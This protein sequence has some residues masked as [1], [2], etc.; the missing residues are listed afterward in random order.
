MTISNIQKKKFLDNIY[1]LMYST[2]VSET[3]TVVRQPNELEVKKEFDN[4]FSE[5]RLGVPLS[6]DIN[7][8]RNS[9]YTN[10]DL[11]NN[12]MA[13]SLLNMEVLYDSVHE[14]NEDL[15]KV[16]TILSK[17]LDSLKN[18][19]TVLEKKVD[20]ALFA[21]AN[22]DGYFYSFGESFANLNNVDL[23]L[24]SC[25]VDTENR[26]ATLPSLKSNALDFRAPGK[27]N[28]SNI[29]YDII[30]N[31]ATVVSSQSLP[32]AENLFDGLNDTT[33]VV[34]YSGPNLGVCAMV[35]T[36]P[37]NTP[38][39]IS[40]IDGKLNTSSSIV[41][42]AE[43]VDNINTTNAQYRRKQSNSSYDR[44]SFDFNPQSSGLIKLTFIK[45]QPDTT[46]LDRTNDKYTFRFE[47][48]DLIVS[49]QYY[50]REATLV[51]SPI[52]IDLGNDNKII[53]AVSIDAANTNMTGGDIK[54]FVAEDVEGAVNVSDFNWIPISSTS[55]P[56]SAFDK[57][58]SFD[59]SSKIIKQI[60]SEA[61]E[62]AISLL[63]ILT[64]GSLNEINPSNS[65]YSGIRTYRIAAI[66]EKDTPYNPYILDSINRIS[67]K[68][69]SYINGLY[70]DLSRWSSVINGT[71]SN[72][73]LIEMSNK[74]ITSVP[75]IAFS[76]NLSTGISAFLETNLLCEESLE[77]NHSISKSGD[78]IDWDL[79][80]YLNGVKIADLASGEIS[81]NIT[82]NLLKGINKIAIAF[83]AQ[84]SSSGSLSLM[85][86]VS[87]TNYG[88]P[89][90]KY[91]TYVDPF[92]FKTSRTESDFVFTIDK[93]L[94]RKEILCRKEIKDNSRIVYY[95]N[96][97]N[98]VDKIR[99]RADF[100]R[101]NNPFGTPSLNEY[102]IKFKN[103]VNGII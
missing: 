66:D 94:G 19:R 57:I 67:F 91:Y 45:Y 48:K 84:S 47:I 3:D 70:K 50:D 2:G 46:N 95:S 83:D 24:S 53:D 12:F 7:L 1:R 51:S 62:N 82:W 26:K 103:N 77:I 99:F 60:Q 96:N 59:G 72:L 23:N 71:N 75:S 88:T 9:V 10:V 41:T 40:K 31:G 81:K 16:T 28:L 98:Q 101:Y 74:E 90:L 21:N 27:I 33:S 58:I 55:N 43:I 65:I 36:I 29:K 20:D 52:S 22:T 42:T 86:G 76:G 30:F 38:F 5:N 4:Y 64:T 35:L 17:R 18:K 69:V 39:V 63:P 85:D 89:F 102:R 25:F 80:V 44:F 11:M 61:S 78:A 87:I 49:G 15:M 34:S 79:A 73:Q 93:Y 100:T 97:I 6:N 13:K 68:Y 92:D 56:N 14:N 37:L 54:F 8:L 32:N